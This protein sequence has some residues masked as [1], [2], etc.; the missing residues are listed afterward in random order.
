MTIVVGLDIDVDTDPY[1]LKCQ[2]LGDQATAKIKSSKT[3]L[4]TLMRLSQVESWGVG[5]PP[6]DV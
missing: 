4:L 6:K 3:P 1:A 5:E 2:R